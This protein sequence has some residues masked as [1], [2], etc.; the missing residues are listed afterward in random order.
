MDFSEFD[1]ATLGEAERGN[2]ERLIKKL[3]SNDRLLKGERDFL[4]DRLEGKKKLK[5]GPK[6]KINPMDIE[7][8]LAFAWLCDREG[9]PKEAAN[10]RVAELLGED[11]SFVRRRRRR[12]KPAIP[13]LEALAALGATSQTVMPPM[14]LRKEAGQG[15]E[16]GV[17]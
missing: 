7:A 6:P 11:E 13:L 14:L 4:A 8:Y 9:W 17:K 10:L 16:K 3:R 1:T 5:K 12:A 2:F 15:T